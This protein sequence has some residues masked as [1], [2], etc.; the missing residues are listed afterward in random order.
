LKPCVLINASLASS[1]VN[2]RGSLISEL[3]RRGYR[4][5]ATAPDIDPITAAKITAIGAE[6]IDISLNRSGKSAFGDVWYSYQLFRLM[7]QFNPKLVVGYTIKPNIWGGLAARFA[8]VPSAAMV[9]GLGYTFIAGAGWK[10]R[11]TQAIAK[12]L[13]AIALKHARCVVF[14][15][16]DDLEDFVAAGCLRDVSKARLVNG[17]GVDLSHYCPSPLPEKTIFL[18]IARL[19]VTKGIREF[20][21]A[22]AIVRSTLPK[23]RFVIA[24]PIDASPDGLSQSEISEWPCG[25]IEYVGELD[26]VR[27]MIALSSIYVLPSY[28]EGTPRSVLEAMA[29]GRPIITTD[30][31]GCRQTVADG[32]SGILVPVGSV[33]EL[34]RAML[35]L[36]SD[37]ALR[38]SMGMA[39]LERAR[40]LYAVEG[41]NLALLNHLAL[42]KVKSG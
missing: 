11:I 7:R 35:Q 38:K 42:P 26:D 39:A 34:A 17:S 30:T 1:L 31:P 6:P 14:Q 2:F 40:E 22:A 9:T 15:N 12:A 27:P 3:Q 33:Q 24:G 36:G 28:R 23:A 4:V 13:Y 10:R 41:V 8:R 19:L 16:P 25:L 21:A 29:M 18:L 20:V 32:A 37:P 5:I